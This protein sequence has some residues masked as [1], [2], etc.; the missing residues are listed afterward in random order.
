MKHMRKS[1]SEWSSG[2][3]SMR[4]LLTDQQILII[5]YCPFNYHKD[6]ELMINKEKKKFLL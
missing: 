1:A 4:S 3:Y 6:A 2:G 5:K